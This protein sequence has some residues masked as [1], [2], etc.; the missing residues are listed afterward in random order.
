MSES[1]EVLQSARRA[2]YLALTL[3][4]EKADAIEAVEMWQPPSSGSATPMSGLRRYCHEVA[5]RFGLVGREAELHLSILR[6]M[7][8]QGISRPVA[9]PNNPISSGSDYPSEQAV[10][11]LRVE[12]SAYLI[13]QFLETVERRVA[14]ELPS[15]YTPT[16]WREALMPQLKRI[17]PLNLADIQ[18][19]L[20]GR[21]TA[22]QVVWP[23]R[24]EGTR[25]MNA[26][27]VVLAQWLGPVKA[28]AVFSHILVQFE[29]GQDPHLRSI[30]AYL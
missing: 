24:A 25:L 15:L 16:K 9:D 29:A 4:M 20:G 2:L 17:K 13:Q 23:P 28:D 30:R 26:V 12:P 21:T 5:H 7:K 14:Q 6:S 1:P 11:P 19:W 22:L 3:H 10:P 8:G 27:Y 18:N